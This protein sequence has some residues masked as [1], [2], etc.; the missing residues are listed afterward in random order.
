MARAACMFR[1]PNPG[2]MQ[3][4][5]GVVPIMRGFTEACTWSCAKFEINMP[6]C[7]SLRIA[8]KLVARAS[9]LPSESSVSHTAQGMPDLTLHSTVRSRTADGLLHN[10]D[11]RSRHNQVSGP[12]GRIPVKA[13]TSMPLTMAYQLST[14]AEGHF[15]HSVHVLK[16]IDKSRQKI[17]AHRNCKNSHWC[18]GDTS[19]MPQATS[20]HVSSRSSATGPSN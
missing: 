20:G 12:R 17:A 3:G 2:A 11:I 6:E 4:S 14:D 19:H 8:S 9:P 16:S 7:L 5:L 18:S 1:G 15:A 13:A 10:S